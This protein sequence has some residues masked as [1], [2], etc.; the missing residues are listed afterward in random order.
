MT[1]AKTASDP[2]TDGRRALGRRGEDIALGHLRA[3]GFSPV[4]RN[5][6]TRRGEIDLIAFDGHTLIF[7][8]VKT[9]RVK[10]GQTQVR[11]KPLDWLSTRQQKR[12]RTIAIEW[13]Y[14]PNQRAPSAQDLRFDAIGV[15]VDAKGAS[16]DIKHLEG[17]G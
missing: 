6:R 3:L 17:I 1:R 2:T 12:R 14:D 5:Y 9:Q 4:A 13:L 16:L 10:S 8:E 11:P 7:V 15:L